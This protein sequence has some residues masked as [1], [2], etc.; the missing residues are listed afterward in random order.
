MA[1]LLRVRRWFQTR[2]RICLERPSRSGAA[3]LFTI[4][5]AALAYGC[6]PAYAYA[7]EL[8]KEAPVTLKQ[9]LDDTQ[10]H[11]RGSSDSTAERLKRRAA[12]QILLWLKDISDMVSWPSFDVSKDTPL[13]H[14][15]QRLGELF[16]MLLGFVRWIFSSLLHLVLVAG[17]CYAV[18]W[19]YQKYR[20]ATVQHAASEDTPS[21][22]PPVSLEELLNGQRYDEV[23]SEI[24]RSLR[25]QWFEKYALSLALTDWEVRRMLPAT[26]TQKSFFEE[27]ATAFEQRVF[28]GKSIEEERI[29]RLFTLFQ[30][31]LP[32]GLL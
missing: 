31:R 3:L 30:E 6:L 8:P 9:I 7:E 21:P 29:R 23:L 24:R 2:V 5:L 17:I 14:F 18:F 25:E 20:S 10:F 22:T 28:A 11:P 13:L 4:L 32:Q 19:L 26:E 12:A 27:I 1:S 15:L 16:L